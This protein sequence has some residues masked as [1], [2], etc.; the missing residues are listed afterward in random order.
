MSRVR[1]SA[2]VETARLRLPEPVYRALTGRKRDVL[3]LWVP[4]CA[5]MSVY[6]TLVRYGCIEER[7]DRPF[8]PFRNRGIATFGHVDVP[9]LIEKGVVSRRYFDRAFK[10]AFVRNP[11]D[12]LVSLFFYL[13]KIQREDVAQI[14]SFEEFCR[15]LDARGFPPVG[16]YNFRGLSQANPMSDWLL[17]REGKL[18][19]DF[20]GRHETLREDFASVCRTIGIQ[21]QIPHEN[22]SEHRPY[23]DHYTP[24][25]RA[26]VEK[27]YRQD[28]DRF[29]YSF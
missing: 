11:F 15:H 21:E 20:L 1:W 12:R 28:L 5:G 13:K 4:K 29:G 2:L 9:G 23:R 10:F 14:G 3:F 22:K 17:D 19:P 24:A 7:W 18:L 6:R 16:L 25:T 8:L 26:I 27:L